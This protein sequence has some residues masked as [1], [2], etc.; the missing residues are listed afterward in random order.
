MDMMKIWAK[1][2][3]ENRLPENL[4]QYRTSCVEKKLTNP[5]K[6]QQHHHIQIAQQRQQ[7]A[8]MAAAGTSTQFSQS[9]GS[10]AS[11][12][13]LGSGGGICVSPSSSS[14]IGLAGLSLSPTTHITPYMTTMGSSFGRRSM[15]SSSASA[16]H[17]SVSPP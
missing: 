3:D 14:S 10:S 2:L 9:P 4:I 11:A 5:F 15:Q 8:E 12:S 7:A 6:L 13:A 17:S 16:S 1:E